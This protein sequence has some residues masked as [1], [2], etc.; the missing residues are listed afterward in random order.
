MREILFRGKR[1][2]NGT[3]VYGYL[4]DEDYINVPFNDDDVG[5]RFD[6]PMEIDPSTVCQYT[7][8]KDKNGAE[9]Y[10]GDIVRMPAEDDECYIIEWIDDIAKFA[11]VQYGSVMCD[12]DNY[13]GYELEVIGNIYDNPGLLEGGQENAG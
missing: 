3:W 5:G 7:G 2:D 11:I 4:M 8:L 13:W 9:I 1:V 10:E 6:E 12:F